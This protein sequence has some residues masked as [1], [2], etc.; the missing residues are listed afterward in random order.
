MFD[1]ARDGFTQTLAN[2]PWV[3]GCTLALLIL[4][5]VVLLI[6]LGIDLLLGTLEHSTRTWRIRR[7]W[8][9]SGRTPTR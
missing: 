5:A 7:H 2:L 4:A 8:H 6:V 3:A 9:R 1:R